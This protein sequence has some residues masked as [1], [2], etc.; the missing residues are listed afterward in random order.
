MFVALIRHSFA[1]AATGIR[2]IAYRINYTKYIMPR[3][4]VIGGFKE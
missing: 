1:P 3:S 4:N 2:L